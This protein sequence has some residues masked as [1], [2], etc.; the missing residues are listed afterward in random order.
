MGSV[1]VIDD[2]DFNVETSVWRDLTGSVTWDAVIVAGSLISFTSCMRM[3]IVELMANAIRARSGG[4]RGDKSFLA[5]AAVSVV[6]GA[7]TRRVWAQSFPTGEG[8]PRRYSARN[9]YLRIAVVIVT[10]VSTFWESS[11][12]YFPGR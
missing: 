6:E 3:G 1:E 2:L 12:R 7:S 10:L 5:A 8:V 9:V 11:L 4:Q